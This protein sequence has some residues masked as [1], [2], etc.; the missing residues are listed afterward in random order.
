MNYNLFLHKI[1]I[2]NSIFVIELNG[3]LENKKNKLGYPEF[4][5]GFPEIEYY[6]SP[7]GP[8]YL[9][10]KQQMHS[11][12]DTFIGLMEA[13]LRAFNDETVE[14]APLEQILKLHCV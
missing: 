3:Y 4:N 6:T 7:E 9:Y 2:F 12:F 1:I 13:E 10:K 14:R 8:K 11:R 5:R